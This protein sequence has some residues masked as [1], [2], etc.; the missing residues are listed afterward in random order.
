MP[1][2]V[3]FTASV[4]GAQQRDTVLSDMQNL[5]THFSSYVRSDLF[6]DPHVSACHSDKFIAARG[7]QPFTEQ[8]VSVWV[9]GELY[10]VKQP[11]KTVSVLPW[12]ATEI[13]CRLFLEDPTLSFLRRLDGIYSAVIYD[14]NNAKVHLITDRYGLRHL[15]WTC[16]NSGLA[17]ASEVKA[18][19]ALP[20]FHP[21]IDRVS[22]QQFVKEGFVSDNRTWFQGVELLSAG[23]VLS[24]DLRL[25]TMS[26]QKYWGWED[27]RPLSGKIDEIEIA[28]ELARLLIRATAMRCRPSEHIGTLLSGG[29]DS[30]GILASMPQQ[31]HPL[32]C[33]TFGKID[34]LDVC[35]ARKVAQ[36][37]RAAHHFLEITA[38]NFLKG[39]AAGVW[40]I[41][42]ESNL[43]DLHVAVMLPRDRDFFDIVFDGF[44]GDTIVGG[45]HIRPTGAGEIDKLNNRGR[46]L[47]VNGP[48]FLGTWLECR[49]PY[50]D[51]DLVDLAMSLPH[52]IRANSD[53]HKKMLL[54]NFTAFYDCIPWEHTWL[55]I[56]FPR[57]PAQGRF[58]RQKWI[59][60]WFFMAFW[61]KIQ[62]A[63]RSTSYVDY[64]SW[65]R[66]EPARGFVEA[67]LKSKSALYPE[68]VSRDEVVQRW[69]R[70][71]TGHDDARRILAYL[72][73]ELWL[74]QVYEKKYRPETIAPPM[75]WTM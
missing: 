36:E 73:L 13:I 54:R 9:D 50:C 59:F 66:L 40:W 32:N 61:R 38:E 57:V 74:Q 17:W 48:R 53:L 20:G 41:D 3:G 47:V 22:V 42:G 25:G 62:A 19:L 68:F 26:T 16:H 37:R 39:R 11:S 69:N 30:R 71:L 12:M 75:A 56:G 70:H 1:G 44:W 52:G 7:L 14:A 51:N 46:R 5:I 6:T 67:M 34:C 55:P 64:D 23:T 65:L 31:E 15:Y 28:D 21:E 29:L 49:L 24:W 58:F 2:L 72:T 27:I 33:V 63:Y 35:I 45:R 8:G 18:M 10:G 60:K 4:S 43:F